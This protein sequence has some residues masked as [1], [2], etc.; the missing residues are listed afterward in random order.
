MMRRVLS[1]GLAAWLLV[2]LT[3]CRREPVTREE[4]MPILFSTSAMQLSAP[5]TRS[6]DDV[7]HTS[8]YLIADGRK[9][10]V[11]GTWTS[12]DGEST[13]VFSKMG[14][15]CELQNDNSVKWVYSPLKYWPKNDGETISFFAYAPY[16]SDSNGI[17]EQSQPSASGAP[18][19]RYVLPDDEND[20]VDLLRAAPALAKTAFDGQVSFTFAHA[21]SRIGVSAKTD[22][23]VLSGGSLVYLNSV[24]I[25]AGYPSSAILDLGDGS[26]NY[27][28]AGPSRAYSRDFGSTESG[29][30]VGSTASPVFSGDNFVMCIPSDGLS[31]NLTVTYTVV[32]PDAALASGKSV[33]VNTVDLSTSLNTISGKTHTILLSISPDAVVF[34]TPSVSDWEDA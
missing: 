14:V 1:Y 32:T 25:E 15:T 34:G 28:Q 24:S 12:A 9:I 19:I 7:P 4:G 18:L 23:S 27:V 30:S 22:A 26:W 31:V 29:Q 17:V 20:Q 11:F 13:N 10:A 3:G 6:S 5:A 8:E 33:I 2:A 16:K 21:L